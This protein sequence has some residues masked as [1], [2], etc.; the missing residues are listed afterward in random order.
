MGGARAAACG[1]RRRLGRCPLAK[2]QE[3]REDAAR[4]P[5]SLFDA[6]EGET[7]RQD[8]ADA[9]SFRSWP[10]YRRKSGSQKGQFS[11]LVVGRVGSMFASRSTKNS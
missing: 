6:G 1:G 11:A 3:R 10:K 7:K 5:M 2:N 8:V 9:G 4:R